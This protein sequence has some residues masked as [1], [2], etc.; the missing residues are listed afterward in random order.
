MIKRTVDAKVWLIGGSL[1][2]TIPKLLAKEVL[3]IKEGDI[4]Q[5]TFEK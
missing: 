5:I 2:V 4:I 1:V 3:K